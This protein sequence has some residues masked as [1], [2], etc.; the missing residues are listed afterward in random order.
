MKTAPKPH[1]PQHISASELRQN[2]SQVL[3]DVEEGESFV[4]EKYG[5][6]VAQVTR[7]TQAARGFM[8]KD[9]LGK[10]SEHITDDD[11]EDLQVHHRSE[12]ALRAP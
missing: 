4:I 12:R 7:V 2:L 3:Q 10:G 8:L 5:E 11:K 9:I 1:P 6:P